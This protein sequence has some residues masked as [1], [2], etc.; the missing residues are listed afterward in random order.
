MYDVCWIKKL[1][2]KINGFSGY[3]D[4]TLIDENRFKYDLT[5][6]LG[7]ILALVSLKLLWFR[8]I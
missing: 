4:S 7:T 6:C 3:Y 8:K 5:A 1:G 2:I